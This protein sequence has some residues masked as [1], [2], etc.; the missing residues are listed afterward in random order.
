M[1]APLE[2]EGLR[3]R[4]GARTLVA[5][6]RLELRPGVPLTLM[7]ETG[8]GKSLLLQ[9]ILGTLPAGL[10]AEG[11]VRVDGRVPAPEARPA[12]WGRR[13]ALLPQE[14]MRALDPLLRAGAQ[15]A[16]VHRWVRG[17]AAVPAR[18]EA[19][20]DLDRVG[21][22]D[23]FHRLP[24]ELSGGMAQ[25]VAFCAAT[26]GGAGILLADEP[27][28]GLDEPRR[29]AVLALLARHARE[30]CLLVVAHDLAVA[31]ALGGELA[32]LR[33][34]RIVEQGPVEQV[35]RS[36]QHAWTRALLAV[37]AEAP[38][39]AATPARQDPVVAAEALAITRG[40][41]PLFRE[42]S[43]AVHPGE[44]V[45][46]AGPSGIGK[47]SLG[48]A[49]LGLLPPAAGRVVRAPGQGPLRFQK[50]YQ[51]PPTAFAPGVPLRRLLD[52]LLALHRLPPARLAAL[53]ERFAVDP[54]LLERPAEGVSG[55]ELQ[56]VALA[57][58]LLLEP[59]FL[60]ADEPVSRLD[61]L[62]A[63]RVLDALIT[64]ARD[65]ECGVLLVGHDRA[66][67]ARVCD[68]VLVL[69]RSRN[70]DA[71]ALREAH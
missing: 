52:E 54:A 61:P 65:A 32:V 19:G 26:A 11:T 48:D 66:A 41:R 64:G 28:K 17:L 12:L 68:R 71:P 8:A 18:A 44:V 27:T 69:D 37:E 35:L 45:G 46:L 40:G 20:R 1:S 5:L 50:L 58:V 14:P 9:A 42:L 3:V 4:A 16:E 55:G 25:R 10:D 13:L 6:D 24:H 29:D 39:R 47:S 67:L 57:R 34:G 33:D 21:L 22:G 31:R 49:L 56:R 38:Q 23:A 43:L 63:R 36:P 2:L 59:A 15:V 51:D 70:E 60:V 30:H 53:L 7:G 62:T